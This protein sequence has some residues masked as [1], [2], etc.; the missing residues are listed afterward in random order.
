[1]RE[2]NRSSFNAV[3]EAFLSKYLG[4]RFEPVGKDFENA[5]IYIPT[6][7]EGVPGIEAALPKD[8]RMMPPKAEKTAAGPDEPPA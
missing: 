1:V 6:G 7:V 2:E 5:A 8:R 4:G 3:T